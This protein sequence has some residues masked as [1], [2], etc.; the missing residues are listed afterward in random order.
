MNEFVQQVRVGLRR[1]EMDAE[2]RAIIH[3]RADKKRY[4][5]EELPNSDTPKQLLARTRNTLNQPKSS[6]SLSQHLR[7]S[8]AFDRYPHLQ[9]TYEHA[10]RLRSIYEQKHKA[11]AAEHQKNWKND[12]HTCYKEEFAT[13]VNSVLNHIYTIPNF[14]NLWSTHA[15]A[16]SFNTRIKLFRA[17]QKGVSDVPF[18]PVQARKAFC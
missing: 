3:A 8:I 6:W 17:I 16:A 9:I 15:N 4:V 13:Q 18:F 10:M 14:F 11:I 5:A 1:Q 7:M 12:S 2:N